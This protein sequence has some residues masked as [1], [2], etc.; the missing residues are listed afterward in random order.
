MQRIALAGTGVTTTRLGFGTAGLMR[1]AGASQRENLVAA[2]WDSGIRHF[3]TAPIYGLG[4]SERILGR[5][6]R[7]RLRDATITTKFGLA[8]NPLAARLL[9]L[10]NVG[11]ALLHALPMLRGMARRRAGTFY[12]RA[13]LDADA[14]RQSLL[15]SLAAL[16]RERVEC[17]LA[18]DCEPE[19]LRDD[20]LLDTLQA[21]RDQGRIASFGI[22]TGF[23]HTLRLLDSHPRYCPVVQ[24]SPPLS[25]P[26]PAALVRARGLITH[27]VLSGAFARLRTS[28]LLRLRWQ[29]ALDLDLREDAARAALFLRAALAQNPDGI[30]LFQSSSVDRIM[31]N[32][33]S[34]AAPLDAER[35]RVIQRLAAALDVDEPATHAA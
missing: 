7:G 5:V 22:A 14:A 20:S 24:F 19:Q 27:G 23:E 3:D 35:L 11:R 1:V 6:L 30:V 15:R 12:E 29:T 34:A 32:A 16:G 4:E 13:P 25:Q 17:F 21:L 8:V 18:H 26:L 2:A 28:D 10:Q 33:A 31:R 9:P